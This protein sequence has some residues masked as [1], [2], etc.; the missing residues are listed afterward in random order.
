[1]TVKN[2][3]FSQVIAILQALKGKDEFNDMNH[4]TI[5]TIVLR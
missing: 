2:I 3:C 5:T 4:Q 1:M